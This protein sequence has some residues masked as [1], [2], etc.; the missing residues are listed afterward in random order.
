MDRLCMDRKDRK[1]RKKVAVFT[2]NIYRDMVKDTQYGLIQAAKREGVKLLFFSAFSDNFSTFTKDT[3]FTNYD[4]GDFAIYFLPD[5]NEFDGLITMDTYLPD[6]YLD[7]LT[8]IKLA[9]PTPVVT[10]GNDVDFTYNVVNDQEKS[11]EN[12]IDHLIQVHGCKEIVHVAGRLDLAF[13]QV[14]YDVFKNT[15]K[16]HGLPLNERNIV[17][18]NLWYDCGESVVDQ[19]IKD[20]SHEADRML[21]D[22]IVCAN[23]YSAIGVLQELT[24]RGIN[25]PEDVIV[26]GYDNI[27]ETM[28]T[29]PT[30]TTSEQPFEQVG[31][32]GINT[33]VSLWNG[34]KIPHTKA[35]PG[36]LKCNQSCGCEPKHVY[37]KDLLKE[38]YSKTISRLDE[39][40]L[41]NTNLL[42][43]ALASDTYEDFLKS[44]EDNCLVDTGFKNAVM[45]LMKDWNKHK[46]IKSSED[47]RNLEFEV[48]CGMYNGRPI[49]RG[50]LPKGHILPDEMREDP[51]PYHIVPIHNFEYFMGY[52]IIS[53]DLE[54]LSQA[55]MK[56][57][58]LNI[59][60]LLENWNTKQELNSTLEQMRNLYSTDVLTGLYNRRGYGMFFDSF[61]KES[62]ENH[63][64]LAVFLIDMD[65]M[66]SV[67]DTL[68]HDEGDYCLCTIGYAMKKAATNGEICIRSG[69]DEFIVL[70]KNYDDDLVEN[71]LTN[72]RHAIALKRRTDG[73]AYEI[74]VS[75][76]CYMQIPTED[77]EAV[78]DASEKYLRFAD[79]E[80]YIEKKEHKKNKE[81]K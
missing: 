66:K 9:C 30:I 78:P 50:I 76:G 4:I 17:Q 40:A 46:V 29:D 56:T 25:V 14:R 53:P 39:L 21:P 18:G 81:N 65:N 80:M 2:A 67:N 16:K 22:A 38:Q 1:D 45:V 19:I 55:N 63:K 44:I 3:Q 47:F 32:D 42:L 23:D 36:V 10:L 33:L 12:L 43:S 41:S 62:Y 70:A 11:L 26:T 60:I 8:D 69:G 71:Y 5:L 35:D 27:P 77:L 6:Y 73:K 75:V 20:Y 24:K 54:N 74:S 79:E 58:F 7:Y 51:E 61:Y 48:T 59:S 15:L 37:K 13:A 72:L 49:K 34:K 68:G 64:G 28:F 31:K 57:W 52:F